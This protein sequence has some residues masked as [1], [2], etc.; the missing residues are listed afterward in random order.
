MRLGTIV[1]MARSG[2][3]ALLLAT[4]R[5]MRASYRTSFLAAAVESGVLVRLAGGPRPLD[6]LAA[7]L[8]VAPAMRDGLEAWLGLGVWLGELRRRPDGYTLRSRLARRLA[9]PAHDAGAAMV[10]EAGTLHPRLILETP[11]RLREGRWFTLGDQNG[12]LIARSSRILEPIVG[13]AVDSAVPT[14]GAPRLFE[15][16]CGTG[17]Y[18]RRAA[19]R[20]PA[21]TAVGLELQDAAG[22]LAGAN[23]A[24]WGLAGRV[25]IEVGDVRARTPRPEFDLATLHNN[26]YYFPV[27]ERVALL[28]HV[29][30]FLRPRG[31][32]LLTTVCLGP[33]VAVD[34]LNLWGAMTTGCGRLPAPDEL[35]TQLREAGFTSVECRSLIPRD[36]FY[37]FIAG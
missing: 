9:D 11:R 22:A 13:E 12:A 6:R 37:A 23:I 3:L 7:E 29:R 27:A 8:G 33:G 26:I 5:A 35:T 16:G 14:G 31:R 30:G 17:V 2:R 34:I 36:S 32:L 15:I 4:S 24:R 25:A 19:E 28:R 10:E 20:N 18:I 21:L 1:D